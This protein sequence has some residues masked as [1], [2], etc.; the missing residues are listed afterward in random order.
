VRPDAAR[1]HRHGKPG[2]GPSLPLP[3]IERRALALNLEGARP[4]TPVG[5][6]RESGPVDAADL[7]IDFD[8]LTGA[9]HQHRAHL[10]S[11]APDP[12]AGR[13][14]NPESAVPQVSDGAAKAEQLQQSGGGAAV[15]GARERSA[16]EMV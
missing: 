11:H 14:L 10:L 16:V 15:F 9:E 6:E 8:P 13:R 1:G 2:I 4:A 12:A 7:G 5:Q 3:L